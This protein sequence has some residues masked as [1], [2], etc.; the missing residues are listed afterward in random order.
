MLVQ[1][2]RNSF[3][4]KCEHKNFKALT[5]VH[6]LEEAGRVR[7]FQ[8]EIRINCSDCG[9][10]FKFLGH[11]IGISMSMPTVQPGGMLLR[12][13]IVPEARAKEHWG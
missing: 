1:P 11:E 12:A 9:M 7:D 10:P 13:P 4:P 5:M 6:R 2:K 3:D 8:A